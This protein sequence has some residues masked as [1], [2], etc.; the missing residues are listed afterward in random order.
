MSYSVAI[1]HS[2]SATLRAE[3]VLGQAGLSI[4][5][6]PTPRQLSSDCGVALRFESAFRQDI[7]KLLT[8]AQMEAEIHDLAR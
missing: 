3:R 7:E 4:K 2:V 1:F 5:L 8:L 6:I